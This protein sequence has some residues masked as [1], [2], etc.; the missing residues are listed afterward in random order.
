MERILKKIDRVTRQ[1][2]QHITEAKK[3]MP[4]KKY[5]TLPHHKDTI[6]MANIRDEIHQLNQQI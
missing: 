3:A 2:I 6:E 1:L 4:Q 5:K